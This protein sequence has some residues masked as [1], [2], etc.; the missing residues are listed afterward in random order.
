ML[1]VAAEPRGQQTA[2]DR[3]RLSTDDKGEPAA[4]D[5]VGQ[6]GLRLLDGKARE[7]DIGQREPQNDSHFP[8][9][10]SHKTRV[11]DQQELA[12]QDAARRDQREEANS[13]FVIDEIGQDTAW[14]EHD[15][16]GVH[17]Q[18]DDESHDIQTQ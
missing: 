6:R 3:D 1:R 17:A 9:C 18:K 10:D 8:E 5:A 11:G 16:G 4:M 2:E 14:K 12:S 15:P 13:T 7:N